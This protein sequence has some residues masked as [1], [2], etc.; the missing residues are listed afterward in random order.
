M[1][2]CSW[3]VLCG[4]FVLK[5]AASATVVSS[6]HGQHQS[7]AY[8]WQ[9]DY[10]LG[11]GSRC[12]GRTILWHNITQNTSF[13]CWY[14]CVILWFVCVKTV[15]ILIFNRCYAGASPVVT[16]DE[17]P[18]FPGKLWTRLQV[19]GTTDCVPSLYHLGWVHGWSVML[20]TK[21]FEYYHV[22]QW[23]ADYDL[24]RTAAALSWITSVLFWWHKL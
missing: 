12:P 3:S 2:W 19:G 4:M 20:G 1:P 17:S 24:S 23:A 5:A 21:L 9:P 13:I 22:E 10:T 7:N 6:V 15:S 11:P 14:Q 16:L 18:V 8:T